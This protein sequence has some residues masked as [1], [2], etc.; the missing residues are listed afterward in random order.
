MI[1]IILIA[2]INN[3]PDQLGFTCLFPFV[4]KVLCY[5]VPKFRAEFR[6]ADHRPQEL[7]FEVV[8][9][10][11]SEIRKPNRSRSYAS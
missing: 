5:S 6:Q 3:L 4:E 11:K 9:S 1:G 2:V 8:Q 10:K 7:E